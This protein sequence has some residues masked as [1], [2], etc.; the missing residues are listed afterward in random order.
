MFSWVVVNFFLYLIIISDFFIF[1][2][3]RDIFNFLYLSH[4][5][6][7]ENT[8]SH[9]IL[10]H[11]SLSLYLSSHSVFISLTFSQDAPTLPLSNHTTQFAL[12]LLT[13][14]LSLIFS[15]EGIINPTLW[16]GTSLGSVIQITLLLPPV[17]I[18]STT[19]ASVHPSGKFYYYYYYYYYWYSITTIIYLFFCIFQGL[20]FEWRVLLWQCRFWT[21]PVL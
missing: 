13:F 16:V 10:T 17:D 21:V 15:P 12:H 9:H 4:S 7:S 8:A 1:I 6:I 3:F 14:S 19:P 11:L 20:F 2:G 5:S 18:R